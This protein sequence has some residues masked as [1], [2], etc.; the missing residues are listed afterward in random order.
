MPI[1][2]LQSFYNSL[3]HFHETT[4]GFFSRM[5]SSAPYDTE[6]N[7]QVSIHLL[8]YNTDRQGRKTIHACVSSF[9]TAVTEIS[10]KN[11]TSSAI[12]SLSGKKESLNL[13]FLLHTAR[14][15]KGTKIQSI[16]LYEDSHMCPCR[17]TVYGSIVKI[18]KKKKKDS[19]F[20]QQKSAT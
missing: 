12:P 10:S 2:T 4:Y 6:L 8:G 14:T 11:L 9:Y 18:K 1:I 7:N 16:L 19:M 3:S 20:I 5:R 17:L 15:W 13:L